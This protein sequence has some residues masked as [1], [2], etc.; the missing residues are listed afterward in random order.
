MYR[1]P[2]KGS[3]IGKRGTTAS[4]NLFIVCKVKDIWIIFTQL[5]YSSPNAI[6]YICEKYK[7]YYPTDTITYIL[8]ILNSKCKIRN[9]ESVAAQDTCIWHQR[10][11]GGIQALWPVHVMIRCRYVNAPVHIVLLLLCC[12]TPANKKQNDHI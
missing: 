7:L 4:F 1:I 8:T 2:L 9:R 6:S 10:P 5:L 11:Q 3:K 12:F